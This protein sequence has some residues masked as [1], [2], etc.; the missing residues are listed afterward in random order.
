MKPIV[1]FFYLALVV[2]GAIY[3]DRQNEPMPEVIQSLTGPKKTITKVKYK[4][5]GYIPPTLQT[6]NQRFDTISSV[7]RIARGD[8]YSN[9]GI[10][11]NNDIQDSTVVLF[12]HPDQKEVN[13]KSAAIN[14][15][16]G[17][18]LFLP[19]ISKNTL[20]SCIK[21]EPSK[22]FISEK[23]ETKIIWAV[24]AW[25]YY[26]YTGD[27]TFLNT[28]YNAI[29]NTLQELEQKKF[30]DSL[31]LFHGLPITGENKAALPRQS[32]MSKKSQKQGNTAMTFQ[33]TQFAESNGEDK[34]DQF[35]YCLSTNCIYYKVYTIL[36]KMAKII[37]QPEN[38]KWNTKAKNLKTSINQ[39]F[40]NNDKQQYTYLAQ[41]SD[42]IMY[43]ESLGL[44]FT[45]L[46]DIADDNQKKIIADKTQKDSYGIPCTYPRFPRF[47]NL[48]AEQFGYYNGTVWPYI[49]GFWSNAYLKTQ[50]NRQFSNV[51]KLLTNQVYRD[52][53][54]FGS[55]NPVTGMPYGG[56]YT[57]NSNEFKELQPI[58]RQTWSASA[59]MRMLLFGLFGMNITEEGI[60][61]NPSI[62]YGAKTLTIRNIRYRD[63]TLTIS[64]TGKGNK[65]QAFSVNGTVK[66]D[67]FIPADVK[68]KKEIT[69]VMGNN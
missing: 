11:S 40:W 43:Q 27:T 6:S 61:F 64:I 51:L 46:F 44:A 17:A 1:F 5:T 9:I 49:Q 68:G 20:L 4:H 29:Q 8:I 33:S 19:K 18:T 62:S 39:H 14:I 21:G 35:I 36:P 57:T 41:S 58:H 34:K 60:N 37:D 42:S 16:N 7:F 53:Q 15:W 63:A 26:L 23:N 13:A 32:L 38:Q 12:N 47:Q 67:H 56:M 45:I 24:G 65:I 2:S 59:Y 22:P 3:F 54:F 50:Q 52:K 25:K 31:H 55:Y 66:G 69:I 30:N 48:P 28:A 10:Q